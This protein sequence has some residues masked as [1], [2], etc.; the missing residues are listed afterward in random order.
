VD[1][2]GLGRGLSSFDN[3]YLSP[4]MVTTRPPGA[5]SQTPTPAVR[6]KIT[7]DAGS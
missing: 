3:A 6:E 1:D 4:Y 2:G 7:K 5:T